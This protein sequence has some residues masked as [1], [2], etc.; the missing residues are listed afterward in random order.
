MEI[1]FGLLVFANDFA[2]AG[3]A[4]PH[5]AGVA[6][7]VWS[8][9]PEC[10]NSQIRNVLLRSAKPIGEYGCYNGLGS[11]LV[12]ARAAY[13]LLEAEG[14]EAGGGPQVEPSGGCFQNPDFVLE[15]NEFFNQCPDGAVR[16]QVLGGLGVFLSLA[17]ILCL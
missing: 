3:M 6:A 10:T 9:F 1:S 15:D 17:M 7:E 4:C 12:Q 14:C 16:H 11:G 8:R 13:D 5:V 2:T